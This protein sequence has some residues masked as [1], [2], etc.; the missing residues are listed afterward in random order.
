MWDIVAAAHVLGTPRL[1]AQHAA[2]LLQEAADRLQSLTP[3]QVLVE[4][5]KAQQQVWLHDHPESDLQL[6]VFILLC[7]QPA[8][9]HVQPRAQVCWDRKPGNFPRSLT[10][11]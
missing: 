3:R 9:G 8:R 6:G 10:S 7:L 4:R 5:I 2:R 11:T 1:R